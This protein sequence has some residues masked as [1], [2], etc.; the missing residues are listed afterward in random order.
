MCIGSRI[1][2]EGISR[3]KMFIIIITGNIILYPAY[4]FVYSP[5]P[6]KKKGYKSNS[7]VGMRE[8]VQRQMS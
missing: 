6:P 3:V 4:F 8:L 2:N 1:E 7:L 5:P